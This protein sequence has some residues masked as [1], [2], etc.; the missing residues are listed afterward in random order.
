MKTFIFLV[1]ALS[2]VFCQSVDENEH[3]ET[4]PESLLDNLLKI[5]ESVKS[6]NQNYAEFLRLCSK[7]KTFE[8]SLACTSIVQKS[9]EYA[10]TLNRLLH[11]SQLDLIVYTDTRNMNDV[12]KYN[13][14]LKMLK[15]LTD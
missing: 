12:E 8:N 1:L 15:D 14:M 9:V 13:Y 4:I 11:Y 7:E 10:T 3:H 5:S 2:L 6:L